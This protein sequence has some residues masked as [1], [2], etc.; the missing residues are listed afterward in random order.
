[1]ESICAALL[2]SEGDAELNEA[3]L[4]SMLDVAGHPLTESR[5]R[6]LVAALEGPDMGVDRIPTHEGTG[7][8]RETAVVEGGADSGSMDVR[9]PA[10]DTDEVS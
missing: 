1:M 6:A 5:V 7:T 9:S 8:A 4:T 2:L 10:T 3:N